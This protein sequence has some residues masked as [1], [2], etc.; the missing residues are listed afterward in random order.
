MNNQPAEIKLLTLGE[1]SGPMW[2]SKDLQKIRVLMNAGDLNF[3]PKVLK[4][5]VKTDKKWIVDYILNY[6]TNWRSKSID[7]A[8]DARQTGMIAHL[9]DK[10][11]VGVNDVDKYNMT[12]LYN[13][14]HN[15]M[16]IDCTVV[17]LLLS[18]KANPNLKPRP[19]SHGLLWYALN[20]QS[21]SAVVDALLTGGEGGKADLRELSP[22]KGETV[23]SFALDMYFGH[24]WSQV[25]TFNICCSLITA[26]ADFPGVLDILNGDGETPLHTIVKNI[27]IYPEY[28]LF[29]LLLA[30]GANPN[31]IDSNGNT[32]LII[33]VER[34]LNNYRN[35]N[36]DQIET[37]LLEK[38]IEQ[39]VKYH[40]DP[41][42]G[43]RSVIDLINEYI[44]T[45]QTTTA[46]AITLKNT[47]LSQQQQGGCHRHRHSHRR[48]R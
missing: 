11:Y 24:N 6:K 19:E 12:P 14:V 23:I 36:Y 13:C 4:W 28:T 18:K 9:I 2:S 31:V 45:T 20:S 8:I 40:A 42:V 16:N 37:Q 33:M 46:P 39:L 34:L 29:K 10:K 35:N 27:R 43:M 30:A 15:Q 44:Q 22:D 32:A 25:S 47:I 5:A 3:T 21:N 7:W 26:S 41:S 17:K 48:R 1:I 38:G